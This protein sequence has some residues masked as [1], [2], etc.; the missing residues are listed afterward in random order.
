MAFAC[1]KVALAVSLKTK[2]K[3]ILPGAHKSRTG[4]LADRVG[5]NFR[6]A[7]EMPGLFLL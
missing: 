7:P 5:R 4:P 2:I 3:G 6:D 1:F